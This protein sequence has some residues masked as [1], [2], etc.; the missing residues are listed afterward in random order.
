MK[1]LPLLALAA[2]L[3][4]AACSGLFHSQ[5]PTATVYELR[6]GAVPPATTSIAAT[7]VVARPRVRPGLDS[8]RIAVLLGDRRLDAYAGARWS[9]PLPDLV[10]ALL[11]AGLR[12]GGGWQA[13]VSERGEF[14]GRYL[15]EPEIT[16]FEAD[17]SKGPG[18]PTVRVVLH[19]EFGLAAEHR[20]LATLE[21]SA[22]VAAAADR[23]REVTAAFEA[24]YRQA[25]G[26]LIAALGAAAATTEQAAA[27]R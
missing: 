22:E 24:A 4:L 11:V 3:P 8:E 7:L 19:A 16:D 1:H 5:T 12:A 2:T 15:L 14:G 21:G 26:Q 18:A 10:E 13:V 25:A 9:A 17:Y 23:Q 20:P 27:R 6:A